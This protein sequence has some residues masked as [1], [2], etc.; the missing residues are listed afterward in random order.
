MGFLSPHQRANSRH[1]SHNLVSL[2]SKRYFSLW[3]NSLKYI[4]RKSFILAPVVVGFPVHVSPILDFGEFGNY[5]TELVS[6]IYS[7][8]KL[9]DCQRGPILG[10]LE[11]DLPSISSVTCVEESSK[12]KI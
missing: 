3:T 9:A 10:D 5:K 11:P 1:G 6:R 7:G 8:A 2:D 4:T 12:D